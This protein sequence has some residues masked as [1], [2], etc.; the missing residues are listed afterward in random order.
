MAMTADSGQHG[1]RHPAD[2]AAALAERLFQDVTGALELFTVYLGDRLGLYRALARRGPGDL[3]RAGRADRHRRA[4]HPGV[5]GAPRGERAAGG[6]RP[7]GRPAGPPVPAAAGACA[8]PGRPGRRP[9]PGVQR[10]RDR[11]RRAVAAAAGGGVPHRGRAAPAALGPGGQGRLQPGDLPQPAG[12]AMAARHRGRARPA[13]PRAARPGGRP[14]VRPRLVEHR[15]GAGLPADQR[16]RA[17][18]WTRT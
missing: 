2:P 9:L 12:N 14:G 11:P 7:G 1:Q 4:L 3:G 18:T 10:R 8:R 17:T 6:G 16:S 5:A 13:E 15:D